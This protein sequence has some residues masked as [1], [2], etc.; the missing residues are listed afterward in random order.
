MPAERDEP[1]GLEQA[2]LQRDRIAAER[3]CLARPPQH[4]DELRPMPRLDD[5]ARD[6]AFVDRAQDRTDVRVRGHDHPDRRREALLDD[7]QE[8]LA[9]HLGHAHVRD[10]HGEL[11]RLEQG[12]RGF[13]IRSDDHVEVGQRLR[14]HDPVRPLVIDVQDRRC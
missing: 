14:E 3:P 12:E 7:A 4:L 1:L 5:V 9:A 8:L 10:E 11:L 13:R 2:C 6:E